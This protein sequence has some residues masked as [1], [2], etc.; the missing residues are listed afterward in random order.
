MLRFIVHTRCPF[1]PRVRLFSVCLCGC[2]HLGG[3]VFERNST[4][5][6]KSLGGTGDGSVAWLVWVVL[7]QLRETNKTVG[8]AEKKMER[9]M[10]RMWSVKS[11][12]SRDSG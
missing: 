4:W 12:I 11:R 3:H 2:V 6:W 9:K 1:A 7:T 5:D 10:K 8:R